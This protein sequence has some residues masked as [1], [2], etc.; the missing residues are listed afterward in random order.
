MF[1]VLS[2]ILLAFA[3]SAPSFAQETRTID[4]IDGTFSFAKY[5]GAFSVQYSH[6]W[7]IGKQKKFAIGLGGR[8][9]SY[10][11]ANQ[12]YITA[13]AKI[14]SGSSGPFVIFKE[15]IDENID[16]LLIKSPQVTMINVSINIEYQITSKFT[17]GFNIDAVGF[18]FGTDQS[19][20]YINGFT[21]MNTSAKPTSFNA[22]LISD[23]D[24]GS[25]NSELFVKY[26]FSN[27]WSVRAGAQF[28]FT[29]YTSETEVQQYPEPNDRFRRKSLLFGLGIN[30]RIK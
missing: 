17:A 14:T 26:K 12:Y 23:N 28:L 20:N 13:P 16:T 22:L 3:L 2:I 5:Q 6:L 9:T 10:F 25:L 19:A 4:Q 8:I 15:N 18:S 29:E 7:K 27:K 24:I 1:R 30:Y 11:G 21:G